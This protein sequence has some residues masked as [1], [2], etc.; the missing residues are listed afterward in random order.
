ME[1]QRDFEDLLRLLNKHKVRYCIVGAYALAFYARPRYTKDLDV[2]IA[3][4][5]KNG[6]QIIDALNEF[7]FSSM[8]LSAKDFTSKG[9]VIQLGYEPIR[10]D[11]LTSIDGCSFEEVWK[12]RKKGQYGKEKVFFISKEDLI[13]NKKATKRKQDQVDLDLLKD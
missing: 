2:F 8:N 4:D 6:Q 9:E 5:I 1:T 12:N 10:I 11:F 13:K 3:A 7:G